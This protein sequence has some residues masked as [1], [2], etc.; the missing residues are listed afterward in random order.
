MEASLTVAPLDGAAPVFH[1]VRLPDSVVFVK[2]I[3]RASF[4]LRLLRMMGD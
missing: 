3:K 2:V 4:Y 1:M